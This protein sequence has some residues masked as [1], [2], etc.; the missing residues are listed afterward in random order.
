MPNVIETN[1]LTRSYGVDALRTIILGG[2]WQPLYPLYFELAIIG[3]FDVV[4]IVIGTLAFSK[5]K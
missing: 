4:M 2:A 3:V 1:K 5:T